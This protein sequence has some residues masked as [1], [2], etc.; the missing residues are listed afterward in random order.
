MRT[1]GLSS[2]GSGPAKGR[3]SAKARAHTGRTGNGRSTQAEPHA[4]GHANGNGH[5]AALAAGDL[6]ERVLLAV[7]SAFKKGNFSVRLPA[8]WTGIAGRISDT[9]NDVIELNER[10]ARELE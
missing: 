3:S 6:D 7:L 2:G 1:S 9:L 5:E 10:M 4:N 8:E